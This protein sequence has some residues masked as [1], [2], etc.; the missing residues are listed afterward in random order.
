MDLSS[1]VVRL[2]RCPACHAAMSAHDGGLGC[3]RH[4]AEIEDG[5]IVFARP[6][7]GKYDPTYAARYAALWTFGFATLHSGLDEGLYRTVSS[8]MAEALAESGTSAPV[9][10]DAGCGVGRVTG[11]ASR[12]APRATILAF[13]ASPSMLSFA[14]RVVHG[15]EPID[16]ELASYGFPRLT[17]PPYANDRPILARAD[18]E[19][20]PVPDGVADLVLSVN[21]VDRLPHGPE[22]ALREAHRILK[23]GGTLIFTDPFNWTEPWLWEKYPDSRAVLALLE[24]TGFTVD[25]WFDDLFYREILD[26]RGSFDEF[27]TLAVKARKK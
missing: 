7:V 13:D 24:A 9:I 27:R 22:L 15:R 23:P 26:A 18:V 5:V 10:V 20:L 16:V 14:R 3:D 8:L 6:D 2:F 21:I 19:N 25:T 17:I 4:P 1:A 11:D 12:L